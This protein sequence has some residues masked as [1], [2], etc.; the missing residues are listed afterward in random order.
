MRI[1]P[2]AALGL[3]IGAMAAQAAP[4]IAIR[5]TITDCG[6]IG[7]PGTTAPTPFNGASV[8]TAINNKGEVTGYN[9]F[10]SEEPDHGFLYS[11]GKM[12]DIGSFEDYPSIPSAI[13]DRSEVVGTVFSVDFPFF[14]ALSAFLYKNGQLINL[15]PLGL[16]EA[17]GINNSGRIAGFADSVEPNL[18][19]DIFRYVQGHLVFETTIQAKVGNLESPLTASAINNRGQVVGEG[20]L[21]QTGIVTDEYV[22]H[23][24]LYSDG[25]VQDL[26][27]IG[28]VTNS[29][30]ATALN[31]NGEVVGTANIPAAAASHAFLY[32]GG[33][34]RDLGTLGGNYSYA[35]GINIF[36][37][38][39][40]GSYLVGNSPP[41]GS[42]RAFIYIA[43]QMYDLNTLLAANPTGW[44]LGEAVG[45]NDFGQIAVR[46]VLPNGPVHA[47]LLTPVIQGSAPL[48]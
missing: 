28:A 24:F 41:T 2:L 10:P 32:S 7:F 37:V 46:G 12:H 17:A 5:Y 1:L 13:N 18:G 26:G 11:G 19:C 23:A 9:D 29:S 39:V 35:L 20:L 43:G 30:Y 8:P 42:E 34:M 45:I 33:Q 14:P 6:T 4:T 25:R 44:T 47:L 31:D 40:G 21:I 22:E 3:F 36:G 48:K 16:S 15:E 27:A 38:V